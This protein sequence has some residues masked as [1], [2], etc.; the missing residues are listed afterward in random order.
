MIYK[1]LA[2]TVLALAISSF[3]GAADYKAGEDYILTGVET[4]ANPE[5]VNVT[6]YFGYWCPHCNNFEPLLE[7]WVEENADKVDFKRVPVAF[8]SRGQNQTLAQKA[9]YI[10]KQLKTEKSVDSAMFD[11]YHKYGRLAGSFKDL[12]KIKNDPVAC[13]A[14]ITS[15]IEKAEKQTKDANRPFDVVSVT[16]YLTDNVC[17]TDARGWALLKVAKQ[18]RGSIRDAD[19]L[20]DI[21][22]VAGVDPSNFSKRLDSFSMKSSMKSGASKMEAMGIDSVPTI[23]VNGKYRVT[24]S[25]GFGHMLSV[26]EHLVAKEESVTRK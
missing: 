7:K 6:E 26:V 3:A 14:E 2:V 12:E 11:F 20:Q 15:L 1:K 8:S 24:S 9:Y 18:A 10:G 16:K 22:A 21:L 17:E 5:K 23:I 25:K 19:V 13:N 4:T